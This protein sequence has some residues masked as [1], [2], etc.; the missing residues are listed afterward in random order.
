MKNCRIGQKFHFAHPATKFKTI[1]SYNSHF[2]GSPTW[3]LF[4]SES[5]ILDNSWDVKFTEIYNLQV[6][7][8]RYFVEKLTGQ[9]QLKTMLMNRF[10]FFLN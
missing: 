9:T 10:I 4:C 7:A 8:H 3:D 6:N 2:T 1:M 5:I